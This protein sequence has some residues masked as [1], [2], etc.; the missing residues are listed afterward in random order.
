M[1]TSLSAGWLAYL[2]SDVLHVAACWKVTRRDGQVFG[3]T[4]HVE[5]ISFGG[6]FYEGAS[7][8]LQTAID[9]TDTLGVDNLEVTG[10][11]SSARITAVDL[12]AG[13]WD[14]A[15]LEIFLL[16]YQDLTIGQNVQFTG[17]IGNVTTGRLAFSVEQR[18]LTQPLSQNRGRIVSNQCDA[19]LGDARCKVNLVP[20][21]RT[22]SVASPANGRSFIDT[23][24]TEADGYWA[25]GNLTM[26]SGLSAGFPM[27][28]KT[29]TAVG[30]L[31][32]VLPMPFGIAAGDTY[33]MTP[34]CNHLLKLADGSY[35]GDCKVK[36]ANV[37]NFRGFPEVPGPD[38]LSQYGGVNV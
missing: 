14:S 3:F 7:G 27:E 29:S 13:R 15:T 38:R 28:I 2:K 31:T 16:N 8:F 36:F 20:F 21:T 35:G 12:Q 32:L 19:I 5:S 34:G 9:A 10:A 23:A 37:I 24:R 4:T 26:T 11:L 17:T 30:A 6:V 33:T 1:K 22:G 18:G 25:G